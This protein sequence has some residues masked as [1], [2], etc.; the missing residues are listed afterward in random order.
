MA[1]ID[2]L[3]PVRNALPFLRQAIDSVVNQTFADWRLIVLD[4]GST[5]GSTELIWRYAEKDKR[6]TVLSNPDAPSLGSLLNSGLD[7]A[8]ASYIVRQDGDDIS[9]P[10]R[11]ATILDHFSSEPGLIVVG[12]NA[13]LIDSF[14]R[15]IGGTTYPRTTAAIRAASFFHN[16]FAH[17]ALAF[18]LSHFKKLGARYGEDILG[19]LPRRKT[20][21]VM[22]LAEDY[23]LFTQLAMLG[24]CRNINMSLIKYRVHA[25][26]ISTLKR[27]EQ[28]I[29]ALT[30]S[31]FASYFP[32][33]QLA[34]VEP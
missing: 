24:P 13:D 5:D 22:D 33:P 7:A 12:A 25:N 34:S 10:E 21:K 32:A 30:I 4:H 14:G 8:D 23:F 28:T 20:I 27:A 15:T 9:V 3:L 1:R 26:A 18:N 11:F 16:P 29:C 17:P 6:I 2:V 19:A 31:R